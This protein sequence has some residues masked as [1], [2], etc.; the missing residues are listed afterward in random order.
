M[1]RKMVNIRLDEKLW[2]RVKVIATEQRLP[3]QDWVEQ[4]LLLKLY[5]EGYDFKPVAKG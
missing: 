3:M 5:S 4:A 1:A 2:H